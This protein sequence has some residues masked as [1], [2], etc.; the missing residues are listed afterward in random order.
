MYFVF[1]HFS[2]FPYFEL[3]WWWCD[4]IN[5]RKVGKE[6]R[7][8]KWESKQD[9]AEGLKRKG[10]IEGGGREEEG[11]GIGDGIYY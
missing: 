3:I 4:G 2:T 11:R 1:E 9:V 7:E 6:A 5:T 8:V 10:R